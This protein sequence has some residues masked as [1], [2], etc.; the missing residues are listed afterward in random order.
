MA[1]G[2]GGEYG[3]GC[4]GLTPP[5]SSSVVD[6]WRQGER[7]LSCVLAVSIEWTERHITKAYHWVSPNVGRSQGLA[8]ITE[9]VDLITASRSSRILDIS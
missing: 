8:M 4:A 1:L 5:L 7:A 6:G 9:A 2:L 3:D